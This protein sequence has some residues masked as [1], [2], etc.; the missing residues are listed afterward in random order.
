MENEYEAQW[1]EGEPAS[2]ITD[3]VLKAK[4]QER[5]EG[6][7]ANQDE[8]AAAFEAQPDVEPKP[9][10]VAKADKKDAP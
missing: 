4:R 5:A 2:P 10:R 3:A 1:A 8:F 7:G 9:Q 6:D